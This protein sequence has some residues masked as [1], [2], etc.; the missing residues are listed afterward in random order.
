MSSDYPHEKEFTISA[1][2]MK[3]GDLVYGLDT[4]NEIIT[5][6]V[7]QLHSKTLLVLWA[8]LVETSYQLSPSV[9]FPTYKG[10]CSV[11]KGFGW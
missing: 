7:V 1:T 6:I 2:D 5:G 9:K 8:D 4:N 10:V 3:L 11:T